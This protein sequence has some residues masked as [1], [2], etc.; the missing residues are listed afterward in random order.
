M[1]SRYNFSTGRFLYVLVVLLFSLTYLQAQKAE[2]NLSKTFPINADGTTSLENKYGSMNIE[3]WDRNEVKIEVTVEAKANNDRKVRQIL[4]GIDV[5]FS[6]GSDYVSAETDFN[7][8]GINNAS[9]TVT[10][11]VHMPATNELKAS[12]KY[13]NLKL[14]KL[15]GSADIEVKYGTFQIESIGDNS[16]IEVA[17]SGADCTLAEAKDLMVEASY[18]R[19]HIYNARDIKM[20]S[21]YCQGMEIENARRVTLDSKYDRYTIGEVERLAVETEYSNYTI[22]KVEE[23]LMDA[24]Y[25]NVKIGT[26]KDRFV[27][28]LSYNTCVIS[29]VMKG[30]DELVM[31]GSHANF[32]LGIESGASYRLE[33]QGKYANV[34]YDDEGMDIQR[35]IQRSSSFELKGSK[36]GSS[37]RSRVVAELSYGSL[38]IEEL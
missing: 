4:D 2:K 3:V 13:G 28:S 33:A 7:L 25:T 21:K 18:S 12:M 6:N 29:K 8:K 1:T 35:D 15:I 23:A 34:R 30:F 24:G 32:K 5:D 11:E 19:V 31:D 9:Y 36:G 20:E 38:K 22:D 16:T 10:Y 37:A 14:G 17:Y 27:G 26:L